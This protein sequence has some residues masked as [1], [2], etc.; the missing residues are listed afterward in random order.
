MAQQAGSKATLAQIARAARWGL[1]GAILREVASCLLDLDLLFR[2][3]SRQGDDVGVDLLLADRAGV[4][5]GCL[6]SHGEERCL[7]RKR[8]GSGYQEGC[9]EEVARGGR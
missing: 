7:E 6:G 2:E 3:E 8:T 5:V 1:L 4:A 9:L